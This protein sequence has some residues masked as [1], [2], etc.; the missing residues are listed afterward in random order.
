MLESICCVA[1]D[2]RRCLD[3][4]GDDFEE[5]KLAADAQLPPGTR[6]IDGAPLYT[7]AHFIMFVRTNP[8]VMLPLF[9][10]QDQVSRLSIHKHLG[11]ML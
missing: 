9:A 6:Q 4:A 1:A 10:L 11:S 7:F 3:A 2:L 5:A 8:V